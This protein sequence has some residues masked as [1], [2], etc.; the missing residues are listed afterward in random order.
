MQAPEYMVRCN[1]RFVVSFIDEFANAAFKL[2]IGARQVQ[3]KIPTK[4]L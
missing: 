1:L 3:T 4:A 2:T